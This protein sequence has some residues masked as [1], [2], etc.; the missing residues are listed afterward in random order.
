LEVDAAFHPGGTCD[1]C[2]QP[3]RRA[4]C[5]KS[6]ERDLCI[7]SGVAQLHTATD[8]WQ[9]FELRMRRRRIERCALRAAAALDA[10]NL[11]EAT[12][13]LEEVAQLDPTDER[14]TSLSAKITAAAVRPSI[15]AFRP[16]D[17]PTEPE[18]PTAGRLIGLHGDQ[19]TDALEPAADLEL[20]ATV[21][22]REVLGDDEIPSSASRRWLPVA[23]ALILLS[24]TAGWLWTSVAMESRDP[25]DNQSVSI[26]QTT[27][28]APVADSKAAPS[29]PASDP[30][31]A[32]PSVL[33]PLTPAPAPEPATGTSGLTSDSTADVTPAASKSFETTAAPEATV[34]RATADTP[35]RA[36]PTLPVTRESETPRAEIPRDETPRADTTVAL[37]NVVIPRTPVEP[38][39]TAAPSPVP[40]IEAS[41]L[42]TTVGESVATRAPQ[43]PATADNAGEERAI[44]SVL[45]RYEA[46]Y[47]RLDAAAAGAVRPSVDRQAL[48]R[49]FEGLAS[50]TVKLGT[51]EVKVAGALAQAACTGMARWTP[52][53]GGQTQ[54]AAR[55]WR[56]DLKKTGADWIIVSA[57]I[58]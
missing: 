8:Q 15:A 52:K 56:F 14:I 26:A 31:S 20:T 34:T 21:E 33:I 28:P 17:T 53:I 24:G 13:A 2:L 35:V 55:H 38:P 16:A 40:P 41:S 44:R 49:A 39:A 58:R 19:R 1:D 5:L 11:D 29:A 36:V 10:G 43:L 46:A 22:H 50:Q 45:N 48:A 51:C 23:P 54:S 12:Q 9:S 47:N 32:E 27:A 42:G 7:R 4:A 6:A 30:V 18:I 37:D 57:T 3:T 25:S